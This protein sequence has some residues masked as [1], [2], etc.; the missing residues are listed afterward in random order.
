VSAEWSRCPGSTARRARDSV[1]P[2]R[3]SSAGWM[4]ARTGRLSVG[5][6][7]RYPVTIRKASLTAQLIAGEKL[8]SSSDNNTS[9]PFWAD[10]R[11]NAEW[12]DNTTRLRTFI[13]DSGT[14][15]PR[16]SPSRTACVRINRLRTGVGHFR[17]CLYKWRV[18]YK[19][20]MASSADCECCAE[21][22]TVDHVVL[23]C[24]IHRPPHGLPVLDDETI[25][26]LLNICPEV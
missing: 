7:R 22:Q 13:P 9:A 1:A 15:P 20:G 23:Q 26:W 11:W 21:E 17:S 6:G 14:H 8:I 16:M 12:L 10:H 18:A 24:P 25:E 3:R 5:G 4:P 19:Q 2:L